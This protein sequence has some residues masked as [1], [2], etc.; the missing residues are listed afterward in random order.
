MPLLK[1]FKRDEI[2]G[3]SY[4]EGHEK[5]MLFIHLS[6]GVIQISG[7]RKQ[8]LRRTVYVSPIIDTVS[9]LIFAIWH[10]HVTLESPLKKGVW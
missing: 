9:L 2:L 10:E 3:F 1:L 5:W 8:K 4:E 6:H 7:N